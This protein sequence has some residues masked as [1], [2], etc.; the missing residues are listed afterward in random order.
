[1]ANN[2]QIDNAIHKLRGLLHVLSS[3]VDCL[4]NNKATVPPNE[5]TEYFSIVDNSLQEVHKLIQEIRYDT[6]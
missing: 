3:F 4:E 1:M 2:N 5:I 6:N